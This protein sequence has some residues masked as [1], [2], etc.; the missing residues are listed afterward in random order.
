M[1][2][3]SQS[4]VV[5]VHRAGRSS[6]FARELVSRPGVQAVFLGSEKEKEALKPALQGQTFSYLDAMG[7]TDLGK[8]LALI[9]QV[10]VLVANDS[11]PMHLAG[12]VGVPTVAVFGSTD[13]DATSPLG[14]HRIV[15]KPLACSPCLKR[16]C[17]NSSHPF[18][19]LD[20]VEVSDVL[21][22]IESYLPVASAS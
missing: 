5:S 8:L 18:E 22:Q 15:R 10:H 17:A 13:P 2:I 14:P 19:C 20:I 7:K 9:S 4:I 11:G 1:L 3:N 6:S 16:T 21:A 12:L